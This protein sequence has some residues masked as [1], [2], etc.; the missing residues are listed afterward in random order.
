MCYELT[1]CIP[2]GWSFFQS[3]G[4]FCKDYI[5]DL[6][7]K[8]HYEIKLDRIHMKV[9]AHKVSKMSIF[10]TGCYFCKDI[11]ISDVVIKGNYEI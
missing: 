3:G 2:A 4:N 5:S 8:G 6:L 10:L 11:G 1:L 7:F 9:M